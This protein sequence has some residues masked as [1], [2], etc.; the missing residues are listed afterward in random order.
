MSFS[1]FPVFV[2]YAPDIRKD[3]RLLSWTFLP[4]QGLVRVSTSRIPRAASRAELA[5]KP[6]WAF[7]LFSACRRE[8]PSRRSCKAPPE[9]ARSVST[10]SAS[11]PVGHPLDLPGLF[12]PGNA[13][14]LCLQGLAPSRD[15]VASPRPILP[16][17]WRRFRSPR[18]RR[19]AP[20]GNRV[21]RRICFQT[22]RAP[23]PPGLLPSGVLPSPAVGPV[24]WP[25]LFHSFRGARNAATNRAES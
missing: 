7:A 5:G 23:Y 3:V 16:C 24:S 21:S 14:E 11:R 6:P 8:D 4:L 22:Q 2:L 13:P 9:P 12:H 15:P 1:D 17:R 20:S 18:L 19:F 25:L 10:L